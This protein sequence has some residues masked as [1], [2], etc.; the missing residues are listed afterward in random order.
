MFLLARLAFVVL[1]SALFLN[2]LA[3]TGLVVLH[4]KLSGSPV[5]ITKLLLTGLLLNKH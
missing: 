2:A 5:I 1:F 4:D 3:V